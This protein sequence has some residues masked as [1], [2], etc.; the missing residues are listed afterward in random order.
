MKYQ[1]HKLFRSSLCFTL[2]F[3]FACPPV[4]SSVPTAQTP[5]NLK[6]ELN[7][8]E[9]LNSNPNKKD[10]QILL[11]RN[12]TYT[13]TGTEDTFDYESVKK[14]PGVCKEWDYLSIDLPGRAS[15]LLQLAP[16]GNDG[17]V[18]IQKNSDSQS[19]T[20]PKQF[21]IPLK[22]A[23]GTFVSPNYVFVAMGE[24]GVAVIQ[25]SDILNGKNIR[26]T[27][28]AFPQATNIMNVAVMSNAK[29][30]E[31]YMYLSHDMGITVVPFQ[32]IREAMENNKEHPVSLKYL[33]HINAI[34]RQNSLDEDAQALKVKKFPVLPVMNPYGIDI[35]DETPANF[36]GEDNYNF[37]KLIVTTGWGQIRVYSLHEPSF[38]EPLKNG[39]IWTP[40][41]IAQDA[42]TGEK[43][44]IDYT[45]SLR[46]ITV[47]NSLKGDLII[48]DDAGQSRKMNIKQYQL[49]T[50]RTREEIMTY[51]SENG[52]GK[53]A[54]WSGFI[55]SI[56]EQIDGYT[57]AFSGMPEG[58]MDNWFDPSQ[59]K[60]PQNEKNLQG[61]RKFNADRS[62]A[63]SAR[64]DHVGKW[65]QFLEKNHALEPSQSQE[66]MKTI[67]TGRGNG[68]ILFAALVL[69]ISQIVVAAQVAPVLH[70]LEK[71]PSI[72][73]P[74]KLA[75]WMRNWIAF[76]VANSVNTAYS[77]A[78][79][80]MSGRAVG[81]SHVWQAQIWSIAEI[82]TIAWNMYWV[83]KDAP[84]SQR[85]FGTT[86]HH[87]LFLHEQYWYDLFLNVALVTI[88]VTPALA[89][90][91]KAAVGAQMG[92]AT[93]RGG[94]L[95]Q[96]FLFNLKKVGLRYKGVME[97]NF[98]MRAW[99]D[100]IIQILVKQ[101]IKGIPLSANRFGF[102]MGYSPSWVI[103]SQN[104]AW[105]T[106]DGIDAISKQLGK[107]AP[108]AKLAPI[109]AWS[110]EWIAAFVH[111]YVSGIPI[112]DA[113]MKYYDQPEIIHES[114]DRLWE[115]P[116]TVTP[117]RTGIV[118]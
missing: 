12:D 101:G 64:N 59:R 33:P 87:V 67:E 78:G 40:F 66:I 80:N 7:K 82:F 111:A 11:A 50:S 22:P 79:V 115:F 69:H 98:I 15:Q 99:S 37:Q 35:L 97:V 73:N 49:I 70:A 71:A 95:G 103:P 2:V 92:F 31:T 8:N 88:L 18:V 16:C 34:F 110:S 52:G 65:V 13:A 102:D 68:R 116:A 53:A 42:T 100:F 9:L 90:M 20:T 43:T 17:L 24:H 112:E 28:L 75:V 62:L 93:T 5:I 91:N 114:L 25:N 4:Y 118:P 105:L 38:P 84:P 55:F 77:K 72:R 45:R 14:T 83:R 96:Y 106:Q 44:Y 104:F 109:V 94:M 54:F 1:I 26:V 81:I 41:S 108:L 32:Q 10:E 21:R 27:H 76:H 39:N 61:L 56:P 3:S 85:L 74:A 89:G 30:E 113:I 48:T 6:Q 117:A 63:A 47:L 107:Y 57:L 19:S 86:S 29:H 51:V 46:G 36:E 58:M 23:T 60:L